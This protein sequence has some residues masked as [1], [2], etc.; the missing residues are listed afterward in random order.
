MDHFEYRD[1]S[2]FCEQVPVADVAAQ[3]GTPLYLY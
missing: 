2:L 1:G 3:T